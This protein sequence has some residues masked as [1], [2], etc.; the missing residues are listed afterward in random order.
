MIMLRSL[1]L[2]LVFFLFHSILLT[3]GEG[4]WLPLLLKQ[5]N[6]SEMQGMGMKMTAED[7]YSVNKS[8]LKDAIVQFGGGCT[9]EVISSEGLLLTNHHCGY[10]QIQS[11][12][13]IKKN[14]LEQGFWAFH[15]SEEL[16]NK[17][18]TATFIVRMED[19][20]AAA[21]KGVKDK[22]S[23]PE[24]QKKISANIDAIKAAA[25]RQKHEDV[26]I[27][28]FF[29]GNQY[30]MFV[31]VTY[32]DVRL[33]GTPPSAIGKFGADTDNWEW[34][35]HT[36]DFALFRIYAGKDNLPAD[37]SADNVPLKP[38][39]FLPISMDGVSEGDFTMVF[40]FPG[41]TEQYLPAAG[42]A[43]NKEYLN[44]VRIGI[45][46][47]ALRILDAAMR[48]DPAVK[49]KYAAK[50]ASIA[51]AYKKWIGENQ[52][53]ERTGALDKKRRLEADF[54]DRVRSKRKWRK[55]YG[56]LLPAFDSLYTAFRPYAITRD[57]FSE[58]L[59][60]N[61]DLM[62]LAGQA[63]GLVR[64]Y[65]NNGA[66]AFEEK[67]TR[68]VAGL[69]GFYKNMDEAVDRKVNT[70]LLR[71]LYEEVDRA[72]LSPYFLNLVASA[73]GDFELLTKQLYSGTIL[74]RLNALS[75]SDTKGIEV[76]YKTLKEDPYVKLFVSLMDTYNERVAKHATSL[77]EEIAARQKEYM[78]AQ[79][80][81]FSEKRFWPDANSTLRVTYGLMEGY[82]PRDAVRYE[83]RTYLTGVIEK[84]IPG[85]YEFA[86]P[87]RL[88]DLWA[89]KDFG[90]YADKTGDVPVCFL[91][92]NHTTGGNSGS[93]AIDA[94]GNLVGLNFDRVWEGTMSDLNYDRSI[95]RNI[96]V[97][98]R[99]ILFIIDKYAGAQNIIREL[100]LV[101]PK[102][103]KVEMLHM[104][105][106]KSAP[107]ANE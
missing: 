27:R 28:P 68:W 5:L 10:G 19:V 66:A 75:E 45:R 36:G 42:V 78:Q 37:Y 98:A 91:G 100:R 38:K 12:S 99:Y 76:V 69:D 80:T 14:Y 56:D 88:I 3:A 87:E 26:N 93:P 70:A 86:V 54:S 73:G 72:H 60:R 2:S 35:R 59:G 79:M 41:R 15:K 77:Q 24:K 97:D 30:F 62:S 25:V 83:P 103:K 46:D 32:R 107:P 7:I 81:V 16:P 102:T 95:C 57:Y 11:H 55:A 33:V 13:S 4:M 6:E 101:Y 105:M 47:Q 50:H 9:A 85:D 58:I 1:L 104:R 23:A 90:E 92:S 106:E 29:Y 20:T 21:L 94:N 18:L 44:P 34:P 65:E 96:M 71:I 74:T 31:T 8:S 49:I 43:L 84:H 48:A 39:H 61:I 82:E 40:G 17:G 53:L 89:M 64:T 67:W 22:M 63:S 51:N 52:G